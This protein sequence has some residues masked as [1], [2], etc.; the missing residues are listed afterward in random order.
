M[1]T[2]EYLVEHGG[3]YGPAVSAGAAI[4]LMGGAVSLLVVVRRLAL[5]GQGVSHAAFGAVGLAAALGLGGAGALAQTGLVGVFC[6]GAALGMAWL[7]GARGSRFGLR[8]D[9]VIAVFL[10]AS[11]A[12]GMLLLS[13]AGRSGG[14]GVRVESWL[15][16]SIFSVGRGDALLAWS[17]ALVVVGALW[18][19][20]RPLMLWVFDEGG[21][22]ALGV[23]TGRVRALLLVALAASIVVSMKLAGVLLATSLMV[24]PGAT[25]LRLTDRLWPAQALCVAAAAVGVLAGLVLSF[26]TDWPPGPSIVLVQVALLGLAWAPGAIAGR[27]GRGAGV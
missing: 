12:L 11:M 14:R 4:A 18:L 17:V 24:L 20:R 15:F 13:E 27:G 21:A 9:T 2:I 16:G 22:E 25:A 3:L 1:R 8:E 19:W 10:V 7:S 26:E 5:V 23:P 6:V